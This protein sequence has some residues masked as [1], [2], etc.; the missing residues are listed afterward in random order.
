[1]NR[2]S[3]AILRGIALLSVVLLAPLGCGGESTLGAGGGTAGSGASAGGAGSSGTAGG[4][5]TTSSNCLCD[6]DHP[7]TCMDTCVYWTCRTVP[8]QFGNKV[9]CDAHQPDGG[10]HGPGSYMCPEFSTPGSHPECPGS[11]APGQGGW[12]CLANST[13]LSCDRSG[14]GGTAGSSGGSAGDGGGM[15]GWVCTDGEFRT[16]RNDNPN[17]PG[18]GTWDCRDV[19]Q[20]DGT[21]RTTCTGMGDG[22]GSGQNGFN[23]TT[24]GEFQVCTGGPQYPDGGGSGQ[25]MCVFDGDTRVCTSTAPPGGGMAGTGG[26]GGTAGAGGGTGGSG[27]PLICVPGQ[28]RWCD[29]ATYCSWGKQTCTPDGR[30]GDCVEGNPNTGR[31]SGPAGACACYYPF[32]FNSECCETPDCLVQGEQ[33]LPCPGT[34]QPLCAPCGDDSQ[35]G[36]G[37]CARAL[38]QVPDPQRGGGLFPTLEQFCSKTCDTATDCG[39]GYNCVRPNGSPVKICVPSDGSCFH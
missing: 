10:A 16:C 34:N 4:T 3:N 36:S 26:G 31:T 6:P 29:G 22:S 35:C 9:H 2:S 37:I 20:P 30:W 11:D 19:V 21:V 32:A 8:T 13:M 5:T 27:T 38:R 15:A 14:D 18:G 24:V 39:G 7:E 17:V 33:P 12:N 1:M 25:W 28:Q 23:C